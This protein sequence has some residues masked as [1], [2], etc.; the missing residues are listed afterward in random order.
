MKIK[1]FSTDIFMYGICGSVVFTLQKFF[2][3]VNKKTVSFLYR[4]TVAIFMN[5][6][7]LTDSQVTSLFSQ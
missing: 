6:N 5:T 4:F 7:I 2:A 1:I 3:I